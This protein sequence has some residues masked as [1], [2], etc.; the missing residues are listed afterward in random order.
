VAPQPEHE[1]LFRNASFL[2][3]I[4][5]NVEMNFVIYKSLAAA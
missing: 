3:E 4:V 1:E 5:R 2:E